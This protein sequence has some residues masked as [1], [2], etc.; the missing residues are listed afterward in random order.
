MSKKI[1]F[2]LKKYHNLNFRN[3]S[4]AFI[5]KLLMA[6]FLIMRVRKRETYDVIEANKEQE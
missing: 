6:T 2:K 1:K 5:K 4:N 3:K